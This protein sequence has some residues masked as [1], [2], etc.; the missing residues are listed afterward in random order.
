MQHPLREDDISITLFRGLEGLESLR[1]GWNKIVSVMSRRNFSHLWEWYHGY[2]QW[3]EPDPASILFFLFEK[4]GD[5]IAIFPL[6]A[7]EV[8]LRGLKLS[9][10]AFI[11][12]AHMQLCDVI[13]R[14]DTL[15]LPLF[16][17]LSRHLRHLDE[18][19]D[20]IQLPF[21]LEDACAVRAVH[22]RPPARLLLRFDTRCD[23]LDTTGSYPSF[24]SGLPKKFGGSLKRAKQ[25]L[26]ELSGVEFAFTREGPELEERFEAFLD[27]EA[28]GWKGALGSGTAIKLDPNLTGFYRT[29]IRSLSDSGQLSINTLTAE[30][31]CIAAQFCI[32]L[33]RTAFLLK[34]GYDEDYRHC[35]PGNLLMDRFVQKCIEDDAID[36]I[37]LIAES[38]W[39]TLWRAKTCD[40]YRLYHFN[41]TPAGLLGFACLKTNQIIRKNYQ[42]RIQP[43]IAGMMRKYKGL[44]LKSA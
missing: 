7:T 30:G 8:S 28:S 34:L 35:A 2:L 38:N 1:E 4:E 18:S 42:S 29:L 10:L 25:S 17:L 3:L 9:T 6:R 15:Q 21:L 11:S 24:Q 22:N 16:Q 33:D 23:F 31:K 39:L 27:V 40:K 41:S 36:S 19:W 43:R 5:P 20:L 44:R 26:A 13:S 37:N 12:H 14:D 32:T